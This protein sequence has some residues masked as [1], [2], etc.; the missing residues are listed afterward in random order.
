[1]ARTSRLDPKRQPREATQI[2]QPE[3]LGLTA[4]RINVLGLDSQSKFS[5]KTYGWFVPQ[6]GDEQAGLVQPGRLFDKFACGARVLLIKVAER[7]VKEKELAWLAQCAK[8]CDALPLP[9]GESFY[10]L[11]AEFLHAHFTKHFID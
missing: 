2:S 9:E 3:P 6:G 10:A 7:L 11:L 4:L 1:M 5:V 8:Q